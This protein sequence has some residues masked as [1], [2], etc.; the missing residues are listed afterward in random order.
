MDD[1]NAYDEGVF[2][3]KRG[4]PATCNREMRPTYRQSWCSGWYDAYFSAK[5]EWW[6]DE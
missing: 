1:R 6:W 5:F 2:A 3:F 4:E